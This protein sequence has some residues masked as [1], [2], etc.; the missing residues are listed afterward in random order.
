LKTSQKA[1]FFDPT[2]YPSVGKLINSDS[3]IAHLWSLI[4][5]K[6]PEDGGYVLRIV[7]SN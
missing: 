7:G 3:T 2:W 4:I 6:N 1:V 5:L